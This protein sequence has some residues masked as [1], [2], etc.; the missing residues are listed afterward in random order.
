MS[1]RRR[2]V[3]HRSFLR[4]SITF[5]NGRT[6]IDCLIRDLS[7]LGARVTFSDAVTVPDIFD[8]YIPQKEQT[9]RARVLWR[10]GGELGISFPGT[11]HQS[12]AADIGDLAARVAQLEAE[13]ATLRR[14]LKR[15]KASAAA[16]G[17]SKA[18]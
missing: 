15:L 4:G 12:P 6:A 14:M 1:E 10:H 13:V 18:A 7:D 8:I 9:L 5:N 3:R 2:S 17:D 11:G 16:D